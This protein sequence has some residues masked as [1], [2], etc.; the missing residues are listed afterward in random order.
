MK[1]EIDFG[2]D[3]FNVIKEYSCILN[4]IQSQITTGLKTAII[5]ISGGKDSTIVAKLLD[6]K[7]LH[8]FNNNISD[9]KYHIDRYP[10]SQVHLR[11][12]QG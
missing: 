6:M 2:M 7:I 1:L 8:L 12:E 4:F 11:L 5:G 10:D 3:N 9:I